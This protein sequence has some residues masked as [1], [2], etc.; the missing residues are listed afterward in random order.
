MDVATL[1]PQS[2]PNCNGHGL[3]FRRLLETLPAAAYSTDA[4]GL[5]TY[6]NQ[7]AAE[8]WGREPKLCD[9]LDRY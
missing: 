5:I 9:P 2:E 3:D 8:I 4:D 1:T 6:F 7:R